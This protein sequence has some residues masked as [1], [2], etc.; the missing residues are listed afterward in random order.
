MAC[1]KLGKKGCTAVVRLS[2]SVRLPPAEQTGV[3]LT[4]RRVVGVEVVN[5]NHKHLINSRPLYK[6]NYYFTRASGIRPACG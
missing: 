6:L 2:A 4:E 1:A 3:V 5:S